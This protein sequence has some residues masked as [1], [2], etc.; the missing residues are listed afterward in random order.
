MESVESTVSDFKEQHHLKFEELTNDEKL[1]TKE[2]EAYEKKIH[3]WTTSQNNQKD[4]EVKITPGLSNKNS[5]NSDLL[6]EV[7]DFDVRVNCCYFVN[8]LN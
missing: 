6:K 7:V 5:E 1:L 3:N 2:I 8:I 4:N